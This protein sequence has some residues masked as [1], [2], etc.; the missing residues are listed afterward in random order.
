M[1]HTL[2]ILKPTTDTTVTEPTPRRRNRKQSRRTTLTVEQLIGEDR[3]PSWVGIPP[4]MYVDPIKPTRFAKAVTWLDK[5]KF[6]S[7]ILSLLKPMAIIQTYRQ[8]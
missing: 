2:V 4:P 8:F 1:D 5:V 3:P 7:N 6:H